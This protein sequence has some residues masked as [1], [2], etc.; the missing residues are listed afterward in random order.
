MVTDWIPVTDVF[1]TIFDLAALGDPR[2]VERAWHEALVRELTAKLSL[3]ALLERYPRHRGSRILRE[4]LASD[5]PVGFT[6]ND[7]EEAFLALVDA[8]G[9]RRPR[10]NAALALRGRFYEIDAL[11]EAERVAVEL[12]SRSVHST[13]RNFESDRFRDRILIAEG[14]RTMRIT[15]RQL[16][17]EPIAIVADLRLA[18]GSL[19]F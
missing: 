18:L 6:R 7:F 19:P 13:P 14:Y 17:H 4:L 8:H 1:R 2:E 16:Q 12:D 15:W 5:T 11:W 10:M 3:P 9:V